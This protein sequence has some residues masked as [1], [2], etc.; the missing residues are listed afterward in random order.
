VQLQ[1]LI[2][3]LLLN[4]IEAMETAASGAKTLRISTKHDGS[5][6]VLV[7]IEDS[8]VGLPDPNKVMAG[9]AIR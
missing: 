7:A 4:G 3:N 2:L 9:A 6:Q 5:Q 8:G 1:Q